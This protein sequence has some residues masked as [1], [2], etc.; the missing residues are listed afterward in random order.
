MISD[1]LAEAVQGIDGYLHDPVYRRLYGGEL[2]GRL[3]ALRNDMDAMRRELGEP[4]DPE[5]HAGGGGSA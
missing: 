5:R 3:L 4:R 2:R 1:V